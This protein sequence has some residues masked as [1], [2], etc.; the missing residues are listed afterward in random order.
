MNDRQIVST[1][2]SVLRGWLIDHFINQQLDK[3]EY[4]LLTASRGPS[5]R[6]V[7]EQWAWL[8]QKVGTIPEEIHKAEIDLMYAVAAGKFPDLLMM[9][10]TTSVELL[11]F[12]DRGF[13]ETLAAKIGR[14][15]EIEFDPW[16]AENNTEPGQRPI[17]T[18]VMTPEKCA[19]IRLRDLGP[20]SSDGL[21]VDGYRGTLWAPR[22]AVVAVLVECG[23]HPVSL[24]SAWLREAPSPP[25]RLGGDEWRPYPPAEDLAPVPA[26]AQKLLRQDL[27]LVD[28]WPGSLTEG[29]LLK[30][31]EAQFAKL[32]PERR[33]LNSRGK[34][35]QINLDA[36]KR[37]VGL[38]R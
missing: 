37:A 23:V 27:R 7:A 6:P 18:A 11:P 19:N 3:P 13:V 20:S 14:K 29:Q 15:L 1:A 32:L 25:P 28:A 38:K 12:F 4:L 31:A 24:P 5:Q 17:N 2:Q 30:I 36:V 21:L 10:R 8:R 22:T 9:C 34:P 26:F 16:A 33:P 35:I